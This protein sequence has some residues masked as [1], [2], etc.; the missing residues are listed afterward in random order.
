MPSSTTKLFKHKYAKAAAIFSFVAGVIT[1]DKPAQAFVI[2]TGFEGNCGATSWV[3][4]VPGNGSLGITPAVATLTSN[5]DG[6]VQATFVT[7]LIG[8]SA[9]MGKVSFGYYYQTNDR[10]GSAYD[11]FGYILN[12]QFIPIVPPPYLDN[13]ESVSGDFSFNVSSSDKTFGFYAEASDSRFGSATTSITDFRYT[14]I[15]GPLPILGLPAA[16]GFSRKLRRQIKSSAA[17]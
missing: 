10:D 12:G 17:S 6:S 11:A 1:L 5:D 7:M 16:F 15:P 13:G 8:A 14:Q 4:S 2:C 9:P 3:T